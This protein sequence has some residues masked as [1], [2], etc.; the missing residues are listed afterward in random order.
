MAPK[1]IK[2]TSLTEDQNAILNDRLDDFNDAPNGRT[3]KETIA[4]R[5]AIREQATEALWKINPSQSNHTKDELEKVR[6]F[7]S[8]MLRFIN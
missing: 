3:K 8:P 2:K 4:R 1:N 5:L 7:A 6:E